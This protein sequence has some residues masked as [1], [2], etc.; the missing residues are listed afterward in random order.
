MQW[1]CVPSNYGYFNTNRMLI[2]SVSVF[3]SLRL[4]CSSAINLEATRHKK[5]AML[6]TLTPQ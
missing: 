1:R 6:P 5:E 4:L 2:I 3:K